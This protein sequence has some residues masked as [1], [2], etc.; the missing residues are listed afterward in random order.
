MG[1]T[2]VIAEGNENDAM[3]STE[4]TMEFIDLDGKTKL[5]SRSEYVSAEALKSVMD[6]GMLQGISETWDRLE[7]QL[8]EV[9]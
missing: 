6:M 4:V 9:K 8:S 7:E 2:A 3:P 1:A 5:V